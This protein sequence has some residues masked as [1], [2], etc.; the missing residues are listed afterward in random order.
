MYSRLMLLIVF[1]CL[2]SLGMDVA[3]SVADELPPPSDVQRR[4]QN[5]K[6]FDWRKFIKEFSKFE[7]HGDLVVATFKELGKVAVGHKG[8]GIELLLPYAPDWKFESSKPVPVSASSADLGM[9]VRVLVE[10]ISKLVALGGK[11][12]KADAAYLCMMK[13]RDAVSKQNAKLMNEKLSDASPWFWRYELPLKM[14]NVSGLFEYHLWTFKVRNDLCYKYDMTILTDN[15]MQRNMFL[16]RAIRYV[17]TFETHFIERAKGTLENKSIEVPGPDGSA[18]TN[19]SE[20]KK[21]NPN[22]KE[23]TK[24]K[25]AIRK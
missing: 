22:D 16:N 25:K 20:P 6:D 3:Q 17:S 2:L 19:T 14:K 12:A 1:V 24:Q 11:N 15:S 13:Q 5:G 9:S 10:P 7:T 8:L 18:G 21:K 4:T 23:R